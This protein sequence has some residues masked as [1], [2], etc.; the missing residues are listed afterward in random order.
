MEKW[1]MIVN[2]SSASSTTG[3]TWKESEKI[4]LDGGLEVDVAPTEYAGHAIKLAQD[5]A[6]KGYRKFISVGG[7]GTIHE[8]MSGLV[9]YADQAGADLGDFTLGVLPYGTGNDWIKTSGIPKDMS[10]AANV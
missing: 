6:A 7:D 2:P 3:T 10:E 8:V 4:L 5:G 1:L 9:R